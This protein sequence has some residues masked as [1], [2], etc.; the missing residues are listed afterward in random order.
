MKKCLALICVLLM[1][2]SFACAKAPAPEAEAVPVADTPAPTQAPTPEPTP[3]PTPSPTPAPVVEEIS[4][5]EQ[6]LRRQEMEVTVTALRFSKNYTI[7]ADL[8]I[9]NL[10]K[11]PVSVALPAHIIFGVNDAGEAL[12][13]NTAAT[14]NGWTVSAVLSGAESIPSMETQTCTLTVQNADTELFSRMEISSLSTIGMTLFVSNPD[15]GKDLG[16]YDVLIENPEA[17][18]SET[19]AFVADGEVLLDNRN[20][21]VILLGADEAFSN[22]R[23]YLEKK[24]TGSF[25]TVSIDPMF[26]GFTN[27]VNNKVSMYKNSRMLYDID[28]SQIMY[29]HGIEHLSDMDI[30]LTF[31]YANK[32]DRAIKLHVA[33]PTYTD[34]TISTVEID[35]P[36]I[37]QDQYCVL[38]NLGVDSAALG[39]EVLLIDYENITQTYIKTLDLTVQPAYGTCT[40]DGAEYPLGTY[41]TYCYPYTHGYMMLWPVGAPEGTLSGAK[42]I[43]LRLYITRIH[44]GHYDPVS[45]TGTITIPLN[46]A[47]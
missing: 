40:V 32:I 10:T 23:L 24:K 41:C 44:S 30:Y 8:S 19:D 42:E 46:P 15:S 3:E 28:G 13:A 26:G 37:Y 7:E 35:A 27:T 1:T 39:R 22:I 14:V 11:G 9:T 34:S 29:S 4:L 17:D 16:S 20:M 31:E 36:I 5:N 38:K 45:G 2:C 43:T 21:K 33:N 12:A 18:L 47:G 25:A 6:V